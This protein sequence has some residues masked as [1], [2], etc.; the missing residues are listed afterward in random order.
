MSHNVA[1]SAMNVFLCK[2]F[3]IDY[4]RKT[5]MR[6]L[7]RCVAIG[8]QLAPKF[9]RISLSEISSIFRTTKCP[10]LLIVIVRD[11]S[12]TF[13]TTL[14]GPRMLSFCNKFAR[15]YKPITWQLHAMIRMMLSFLKVCEDDYETME[16]E[17]WW[18]ND[19]IFVKACK[20]YYKTWHC[21]ATIRMVLSL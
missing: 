12:A 15:W 11:N 18:S 3:A 17:M 1:K 9:G 6:S 19:A 5:H 2:R 20:D 14:R 8:R 10:S 7:K 4:K 16:F 13:Q 21:Y